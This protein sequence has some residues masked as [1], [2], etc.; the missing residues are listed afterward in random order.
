MLNHC[1][2]LPKP[3]LRQYFQRSLAEHVLPQYHTPFSKKM[4]YDSILTY[5]LLRHAQIFIKLNHRGREFIQG[6]LTRSAGVKDMTGVC[7]DLH[8]SNK[9]ARTTLEPCAK[10]VYWQ[11][12]FILGRLPKWNAW[13]GTIFSLS[14]NS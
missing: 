10:I 14:Q 7:P 12:S 3:N 2:T 5:F 4:W 8:G 6:I 13:P 1:C 9:I 11:L